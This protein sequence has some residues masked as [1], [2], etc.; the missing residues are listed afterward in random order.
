MLELLMDFEN[1][2]DML[3][4]QHILAQKRY[5]AENLYD[6][7]NFFYKPTALVFKVRCSSFI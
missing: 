3:E 2:E 4:D 7:R 5:E 6:D 1:L